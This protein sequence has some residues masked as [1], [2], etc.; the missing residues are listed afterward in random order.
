[1]KLKE[2]REFLN[3]MVKNHPEADEL[4]V[5]YSKDDEGNGYQQVH[6]TPTVGVYSPQEGEFEA[7]ECGSEEEPNSICI[8]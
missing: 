4:I 3:E 7:N 5:V 6:Y 8:N 1:M 2:Y